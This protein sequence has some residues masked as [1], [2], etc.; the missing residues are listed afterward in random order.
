MS[1]VPALPY[2]VRIIKRRYNGNAQPDEQ[3]SFSTLAGALECRRRALA[4]PNTHRV[5][6]LLVIDETTP[7][8][9]QKEPERGIKSFRSE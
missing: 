6:T 3:H 8:H 7:Q 2:K 4:R 9:E 1:R 5:E